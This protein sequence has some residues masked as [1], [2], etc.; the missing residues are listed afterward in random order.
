MATFLEPKVAPNIGF[1]FRV[2]HNYKIVF[3]YDSL[4]ASSGQATVPRH[5]LQSIEQC[6]CSS[7]KCIRVLRNHGSTFC[8]GSLSI[9]R[10]LVLLLGIRYNNNNNNKVNLFSATSRRV[11]ASTLRFT[12]TKNIKHTH[13]AQ[14]L[15]NSLQNTSTTI[16]TDKYMHGKK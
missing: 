5:A 3:H 13:T 11:T 1:A 7:Q 12:I 8:F 4:F 9:S 6:A 10:L 15:Q 14:T 2:C 16:Y